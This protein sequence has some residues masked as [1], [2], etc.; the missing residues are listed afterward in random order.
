LE[1]LKIAFADAERYV[2]DPR[3]F[4]TPVE[5]MLSDD[6]IATRRSLIDS[7]R[8]LDNPCAG[9]VYATRLTSP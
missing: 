7:A 3:F 6:Y 4:R 2:A 5:R 1:A 9:R 8:A